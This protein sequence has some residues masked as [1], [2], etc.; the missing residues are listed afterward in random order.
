MLSKIFFKP[1][2]N[3][4]F[5]L[6]F[7]CSAIYL[8]MYTLILNLI[9]ICIMY[10]YTKIFIF[11]LQKVLKRENIFRFAISKLLCIL[12]F[13]FNFQKKSFPMN[14]RVCFDI[15]LL[16]LD[17]T[18]RF[19]CILSIHLYYIYIHIYTSVEY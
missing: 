15:P 9:S 13:F 18:L 14:T 2:F 19:I 12:F 3:R 7:P 16:L 11:T 1:E 17:V 6:G 5:P 8:Y 4:G 10:I